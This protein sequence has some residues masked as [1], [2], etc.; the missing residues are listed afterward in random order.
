VF[1][2][3]S[4]RRESLD[5]DPGRRAPYFWGGSITA[6]IRA[7]SGL[8]THS[9]HLKITTTFMLRTLSPYMDYS[10]LLRWQANCVYILQLQNCV[11]EGMLWFLECSSYFLVDDLILLFVDL[12]ELLGLT[13]AFFSIYEII[14][15]FVLSCRTLM[16]NVHVGDEVKC[17]WWGWSEMPMLG[18]M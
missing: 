14:C 2:V 16:W 7:R 17:P 10:S 13:Y 3:F 15:L 1:A 8:N 4:V 9:K 11:N 5:L 12:I 18:M 6:S